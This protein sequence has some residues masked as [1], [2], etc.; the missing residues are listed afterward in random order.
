M[1][2]FNQNIHSLQISWAALQSA[3]QR[4][5]TSPEP[6]RSEIFPSGRL[7][8]GQKRR[9][10][11]LEAGSRTL[12]TFAWQITD[13][14][15]ISAHLPSPATQ[16]TAT[17]QP[18]SSLN[19]SLSRFSQSSTIWLEGGAPSSNGQSWKRGARNGGGEGKW[20]HLPGFSE[21]KTKETWG[22][23]VCLPVYCLNMLKV[24]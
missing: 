8:H 10:P 15:L 13:E 22:G 14:Q 3:Q 21:T 7:H 4:R 16:W 5:R 20:R 18:G 19:F 24:L 23:R 17:Q 11:S 2:T 12:A 9:V 6:D 1:W